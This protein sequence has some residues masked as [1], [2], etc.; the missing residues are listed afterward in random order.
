MAIESLPQVV[1]NHDFGSGVMP[2][3]NP[4]D[5]WDAAGIKPKTARAKKSAAKVVPGT[6]Q[7]E[8]RVSMAQFVSHTI[9][10]EHVKGLYS[11]SA[12]LQIAAARQQH[13]QI[14]AAAEAGANL[15]SSYSRR[16]SIKAHIAHLKRDAERA[17]EDYAGAADRKTERL[18]RKEHELHEKVLK[19]QLTVKELLTVDYQIFRAMAD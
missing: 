7:T 16:E 4:A 1:L 12:K 2:G 13:R 15:V 11:L 9:P 19:Q 8:L 3:L 14:V 10:D 6:I 17:K 5:R 18:I